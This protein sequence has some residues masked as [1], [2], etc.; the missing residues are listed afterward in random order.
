[1]DKQDFLKF[2]EDLNKRK[3]VY[4]LYCGKYMLTGNNYGELLKE[5]LKLYQELSNKNEK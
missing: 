1:M 3:P 5:W 4:T 2:W